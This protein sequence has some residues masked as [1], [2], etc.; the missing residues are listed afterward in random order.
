ME[1]GLA[2][3]GTLFP[4]GE[5]MLIVHRENHTIEAREWDAFILN[6]KQG[7][8]FLMHGWMSVVEPGWSFLEIREAEGS[9]VLARMPLGIRRKWFWRYALQPLFCQHWGIC[10]PGETSLNQVNAIEQKIKAWVQDNL[11]IFTYYHAPDSPTLDGFQGRG[12]QVSRRITHRADITQ[13][14]EAGFSPA[15]R[16]QVKKAVREGYRI[17]AEPNRETLRYLFHANP[18]ILTPP[19]LELLGKLHQYLENQGDAIFLTGKDLQGNRIC[20]GIF[21]PYKQ[22]L[23]YLAGAISPENRNSGIM[24]WLLLE[25]MRQGKEKGI[26]T[27]DFEGS[28]NPGIA[29]FFKGLGGEETEYY[30]TAYNRMPIPALWKKS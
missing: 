1:K 10:Y 30:C 9:E 11:S 28:M 15:A 18:T 19:Q 2:P 4:G 13:D 16:R 27:F 20:S 26:T 3:G 17:V 6:S 22:I 29:R 21:V 25:A 24:S 7:G 23:Y 14:P 5:R 12:W 8:P